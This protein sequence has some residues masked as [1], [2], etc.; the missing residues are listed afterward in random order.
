MSAVY[1]PGPGDLLGEYHGHPHDPRCQEPDDDD[2]GTEV[3]ED[4]RIF[5]NCAETSYA[6]GDIANAI[7]A[8]REMRACL[9]DIGIEP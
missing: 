9:D 5:L 7:S 2:N 1:I 6:N 8:L 4:L 3:L